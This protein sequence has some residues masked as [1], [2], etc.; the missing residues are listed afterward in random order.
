MGR[1][2]ASTAKFTCIGLPP[3]Q[4]EKFSISSKFSLGSKTRFSLGS[5]TNMGFL[6]W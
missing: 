1:S 2:C 5:K 4:R 3:M 6:Q